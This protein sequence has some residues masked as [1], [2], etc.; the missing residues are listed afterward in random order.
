[1]FRRRVP[2]HRRSSPNGDSSSFSDGASLAASNVESQ[3]RDTQRKR[4]REKDGL[5]SRNSVVHCRLSESA[6]EQLAVLQFEAW[7]DS[8]ETIPTIKKLRAY[9]KRIRVAELEKCLSKMGDDVT[10]KTRKVVD[11][12]NKAMDNTDFS[13]WLDATF[14]ILEDNQ[15]ESVAAVLY[16]IWNAKNDALWNSKATTATHCLA[17]SV[18]CVVFMAYCH[19]TLQI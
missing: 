6:V 1:M 14:S 13:S 17:F 19:A 8:L 2:L 9:A 11:D 16:G 18:W 3:K 4:E 7:R 10:K 12:L 5:R 15:L